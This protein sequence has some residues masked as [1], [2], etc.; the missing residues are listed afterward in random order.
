MAPEFRTPYTGSVSVGLDCSDL[1]SKTRQEFKA[2]CDINNILAGYNKTGL[3]THVNKYQGQYADVTGNIDY[4]LALNAVI[5]GTDAFDSLP[6]NIRKRF[7]N[8]PKL[9]LDFVSDPD[10]RNEM[11]RLGLCK[12]G[13][14]VQV[15]ASP[16]PVTE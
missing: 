3:V 12:P 1:P 15:P 11:I 6:S 5:A 13:L 2:E 7:E 9:F 4:Q 14:E 8:D 16:E 10:N